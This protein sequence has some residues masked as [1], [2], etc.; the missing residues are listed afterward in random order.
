[1]KLRI[2]KKIVN[3][4]ANGD[5]ERHTEGKI[6]AALRRVERTKSSKR[7]EAYWRVVVEILR[8]AKNESVLDG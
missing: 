1:M 5:D 3:A 4:V 6:G 8:G 2:A 7:A